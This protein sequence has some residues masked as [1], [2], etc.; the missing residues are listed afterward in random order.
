MSERSVQG[1]AIVARYWKWSA[2][3]GL[4]NIPLLDVGAVTGIQL[5]MIADLAKVYDVPFSRERARAVVGALV[6]AVTPV[7]LSGTLLKVMGPTLAVLP[8]LP[9]VGTL[10][11]I[12]TTPVLNAASTYAL[13]RVFVQQFESGGTFLD[14]DPDRVRE[15][16]RRE[17]AAA[18]G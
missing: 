12:L 8:I 16:Y 11:A 1:D 6:G 9:A 18:R 17:F 13:G 10:V 5:N 3:A 15:H 14:M 2:A 7:F 4:L